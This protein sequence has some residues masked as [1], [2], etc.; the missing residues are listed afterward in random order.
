MF[1]RCI[2]F[3]YE[4]QYPYDVFQEWYGFK[5][6]R[7]KRPIAQYLLTGTPYESLD[8]DPKRNFGSDGLSGSQL[9]EHIYWSLWAK[10]QRRNETGLPFTQR[11]TDIHTD[12]HKCAMEID[13]LMYRLADKYGIE[14]LRREALRRLKVNILTAD[15]FDFSSA[16]HNC[17]SDFDAMEVEMKKAIAHG[18]QRHYGHIRGA[19]TEKGIAIRDWLYSDDE[20]YIMVMDSF[21]EVVKFARIR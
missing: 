11:E 2:E 12:S 20:L 4:R 3:I 18:V 16:L 8:N 17:Y 10:E 7:T 13:M 15:Y 14:S 9:S 21:E 6:T 19:R 1:A 5:T